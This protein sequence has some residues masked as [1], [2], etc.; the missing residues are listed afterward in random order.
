M[1][2]ANLS[3]VQ[4]KGLEFANY[5]PN[6]AFFVAFKAADKLGYCSIFASFIPKSHHPKVI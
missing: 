5:Y 2:Y 3:L 4:I 6:I 1:T